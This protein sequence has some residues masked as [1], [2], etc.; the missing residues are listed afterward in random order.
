M[1]PLL[2]TPL[3]LRLRFQPLPNH[4]TQTLICRTTYLQK[5]PE[6]QHLLYLL[7]NASLDVLFCNLKRKNKYCREDDIPNMHLSL[8]Q[9]DRDMK[10]RSFRSERAIRSFSIYVL[11]NK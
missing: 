5:L 10:V 1:A 11:S 3:Q 2:F 9:N 4:Q 7:D 6:T 8:Y